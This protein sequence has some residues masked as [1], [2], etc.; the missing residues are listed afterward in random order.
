AEGEGDLTRRLDIR[1]RDEVGETA[2]WFNT[3]IGK[4]HGIMA[5]VRAAAHGAA[6]ASQQLSGGATELS[7]GAREQAASLEETAAS[8]EELAGTV[9]QNADNALQANQLAVGSRVTAEK[10]RQVV[11]D[12]GVAMGQITEASKQI[13]QI[14]GTIDE[15]AFQTNLLALNAA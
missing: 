5:D 15:I 13:A 2:H 3:F 8:L 10:G 14:I 7:G 9:K 1:S 11:A 12:A 6:A 4:V